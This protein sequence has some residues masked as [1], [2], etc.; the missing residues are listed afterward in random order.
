MK[1]YA[2]TVMLVLAGCASTPSEVDYCR[3][4]GVE[5]GNP[6]Y[7]RCTQY[8]FEQ[9]AAFRADRTICSQ[10]ADLTYPPTL[11]SR[12]MSYPVRVFSPYGYPRT[13]MVHVGADYQ[14]IAQ[15]DALRMRIIGPCMQSRG[16]NS[17]GSWQAGRHPVNM[18]PMNQPKPGAVPPLPWQKDPVRR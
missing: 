6:E 14:Q 18:R 9:D 11:Y 13:E 10:E 17:P 8:Y 2:L 4:L 5:Q 15:V 12:P 7:A 16:W 1:R 3:S